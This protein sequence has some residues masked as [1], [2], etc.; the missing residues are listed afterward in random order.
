MLLKSNECLKKYEFPIS[1]TK[2][3]KYIYCKELP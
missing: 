2:F 3:V 1:I